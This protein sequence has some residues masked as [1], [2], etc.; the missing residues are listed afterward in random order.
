MKHN[1]REKDEQWS[2]REDP[3]SG[4][5]NPPPVSMAELSAHCMGNVEVMSRLLGMF[6]SQLA[7]DIRAMDVSLNTHDAG[8]LA[9]R[10]H[11]LKG[12]AGAVG[13]QGVWK[14]AGQI[15]SLAQEDRLESIA[16]V[17]GELH[18]EADRCIEFL[19]AVKSSI[20]SCG[21]SGGE[22]GEGRP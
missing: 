7:S 10:A 5:S 4:G 19:P 6:E 16:S 20:R 13:A 14:I 15:E 3:A 21:E 2:A 17:L 1:A 18:T 9:S 8:T 11:V 22:L 12:A